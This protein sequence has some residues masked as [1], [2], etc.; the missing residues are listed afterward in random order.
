METDRCGSVAHDLLIPDGR[1]IRGQPKN[2]ACKR[3][4]TLTWSVH[5]V[6]RLATAS[7]RPADRSPMSVTEVHDVDSLLYVENLVVR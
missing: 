2:A 4:R 1:S 3:A 6:A 7:S 5:G